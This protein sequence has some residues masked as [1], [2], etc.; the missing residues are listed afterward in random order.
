MQ[1]S[2]HLTYCLSVM[3]D[4]SYECRQKLQKL[5]YSSIRFIL[6]LKFDDRIHDKFKKL[7]IFKIEELISYNILTA[8]HRVISAS[9]PPYLADKYSKFSD[10][11]TMNTRNRDFNFR[12]PSSRT[13]VFH[14]SF[15]C[16]SISQFNMLPSALKEI[17]N[18]NTFKNNL[19]KELLSHY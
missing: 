10:I 13:T 14:N 12:M 15:L 2:C 16:K 4:M 5:L 18:Y 11:H 17:K 3:C 8:M 6:N 9:K 1:W 19:R 7:K